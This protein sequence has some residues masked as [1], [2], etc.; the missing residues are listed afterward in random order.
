VSPSVKR[1][2][3]IGCVLAALPAAGSWALAGTLFYSPLKAMVQFG[4]IKSVTPKG[5]AYE[6]RF[7]PALFLTGETAN[8][9]AADDGVIKPGESV[10]NDYYIR[11]PDHKLL[12]YKLPAGVPVTVL[13]VTTG[14][15]ATTKIS[16]AELSQLVK[17]KNPKHRKL[18]DPRHFLGYWI[19][20]SID[21]VKSIDQ[22][23]QP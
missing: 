13:T 22:Q 6:L 3:V 9:A 16:V 17:G 4:Y 1:L 7:D 5:K 21:T 10:D 11:N 2:V 19:K 8:R 15:I 18:L 12:T 14:P 23:Y 20:T